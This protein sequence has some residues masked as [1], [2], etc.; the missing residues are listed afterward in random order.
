VLVAQCHVTVFGN[1]TL[2]D[3]KS[4]N[5]TKQLTLKNVTKVRL[6]KFV[7]VLNSA[8]HHED[9]SLYL[10]KHNAMKTYWVA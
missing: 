4:L 6:G 1:Y 9:M 3:K 2:Q 7:P 10:I 5:E 8:S